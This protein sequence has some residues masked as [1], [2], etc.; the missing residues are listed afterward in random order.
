MKLAGNIISHVFLLS[1][2][3]VTIIYFSCDD[4]RLLILAVFM[5]LIVQGGL[6]LKCL[7]E[8]MK[9]YIEVEKQLDNFLINN[10][11]PVLLSRQEKG[12]DDSDKKND[13]KIYE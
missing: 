6:I 5:S 2:L 10:I 8:S 11:I 13:K 12:K 1:V 9:A 4:I 3:S 7:S